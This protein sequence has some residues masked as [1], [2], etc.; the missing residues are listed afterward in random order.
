M[1]KDKNE[2]RECLTVDNI[3]DIL[4]HM[5]SDEPKLGSN[6][7]AFQ[8]ICHG[9][10]SHKLYYFPESKTFH[11][12]TGC[13]ETFDIYELVSRV[14]KIDFS[15]SLNYISSFFNIEIETKKLKKGFEKDFR[16]SE[17]WKAIDRYQRLHQRINVETEVE[18]LPSYNEHILHLYRDC[19]Y[20]SW[21]DEGIS[22]DSMIKYGI[23]YDVL[24][25]EI[26]IPHRDIEN[27]L[28]GV[29]SRSLV[30][31]KIQ[32]GFKYMP[33][34]YNK[35][36]LRHDVGKNLYGLNIVKDT[37]KKLGKIMIV[38]GEKSTMISD[39]FYNENNFTVSLSSSSLSR[40]QRD[41]LIGL[42]L[43]E[44]IIALDKPSIE[45]QSNQKKLQKYIDNITKIGEMLAPYMAVYVL[46]DEEGLL[47]PKDSP[48]DKGR[49]VLEA[50][51]KKKQ[52]VFCKDE[53]E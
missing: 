16:E 26:I 19:F 42:G 14:E 43:R 15:K 9:G 6:S 37:V 18:L 50:L 25:E 47:E 33:T 35:K 38:E 41:I 51:M 44:C 31:Q 8:T 49:N 11:C 24:N 40:H 28:I 12:F 23:K 39:T 32:S 13:Q 27:R 45:V 34:F 36:F 3:T 2:L 5:G 22:I 10:D 17:E 52:E 21:I 7:I 29:R 53:E 1:G 4:I 46:W 30:E 48:L 20:Q